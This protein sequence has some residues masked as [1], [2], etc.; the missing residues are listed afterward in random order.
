MTDAVTLVPGDVLPRCS[1]PKHD[2]VRAVIATP[3]GAWL[4]CC[5]CKERLSPL[6]SRP[7]AS[8]FELLLPTIGHDAN[9]SPTEEW[10]S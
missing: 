8:G 7:T 2:T 1:N 10:P 3:G 9:G 6:V 5:W 4:E